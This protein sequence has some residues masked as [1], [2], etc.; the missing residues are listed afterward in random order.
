MSRISLK[1]VA[2]SCGFSFVILT[3]IYL[4]VDVHKPLSLHYLLSQFGNPMCWKTARAT[5]YN[6][7]PTGQWSHWQ[8]PT[9]KDLLYGTLTTLLWVY[10]LCR[11]PLWTLMR[12]VYV[13]VVARLLIIATLTTADKERGALCVSW[14]GRKAIPPLQMHPGM[15]DCC[16]EC[17]WHTV[18]LCQLSSALNQHPTVYS[19]SE[20]FMLASNLF[21]TTQFGM[22][23]MCRTVGNVGGGKKLVETQNLAYWRV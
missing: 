19:V 16:T 18:P 15:V 9:K 6:L 2:D 11:C 20:F 14:L 10:L 23:K 5:A 17:S 1:S 13:S 12:W 8:F 4:H 3:C 21:K 7:W 22:K